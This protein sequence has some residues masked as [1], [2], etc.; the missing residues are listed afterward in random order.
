MQD[1]CNGIR[2]GE[3]ERGH[4]PDTSRR[5]DIG[6]TTSMNFR[7]E[8][9][10][11]TFDGSYEIYEFFIQFDEVAKWNKWTV[12]ECASQLIM[13]LKGSERQV[14]SEISS[15]ITD[16]YYALK[17]TLTA[18]F[19]PRERESAYKVEFKTKRRQIG[20]SISD[21]GH[22]LRRLAIKAYPSCMFSSLET[23][24]SDQFIK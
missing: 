6:T 5:L 15:T 19:N 22:S 23:H 7:K 14:L 18:R 20:E 10:T 8:M 16:D 4:E 1:I 12:K 17:E 13:S 3:I 2:S 24:I 21:Y 9:K 11:P